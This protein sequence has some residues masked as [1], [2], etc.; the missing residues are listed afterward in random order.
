MN[1]KLTTFLIF[2]LLLI[3]SL[4]QAHQPRLVKE[5]IINVKN[6]EASQAFYGKLTNTPHIYNLKSENSFNLYVGILVPDVPN[7]DKDV[8][9]LI[10]KDH[11][12]HDHDDHNHEEFKV[13]LDGTTHKWTPYYEQHAG[14]E[15]FTGPALQSK[16]SD[17]ELHP[18]GVQAEAGSYTIKV[19][20]SDNEGKYVL[21][22][23]TKER[24]PLNEIINTIVTMPQLKIYFEK[25]PFTAFSTPT[26]LVFL[27]IALL[28]FAVLI[29]FL[30]WLMKKIIN[31]K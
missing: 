9:V 31:K 21:V 7:I 11:D 30:V 22:I 19:F 28:F 13:L 29:I 20:S 8:S 15:Y 6:P 25:S 14:D 17:P 3:T 5:N 4:A 1:K 26:M 2:F 18:K 24:F 12:P 10:T 16:D 23:G 27:L